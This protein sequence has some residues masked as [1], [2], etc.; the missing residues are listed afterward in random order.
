MTRQ[1]GKIF[2]FDLTLN[3]FCGSNSG[4]FGVVLRWG[5][6]PDLRNAPNAPLFN[7][8]SCTDAATTLSSADGAI[9]LDLAGNPASTLY[10]WG[11]NGAPD[12][13]I[14]LPDDLNDLEAGYYTAMVQD[15]DGCWGVADTSVGGTTLQQPAIMRE[16][17][18]PYDICCSGC[19]INDADADGICDDD[20]N[21][22]DQSAPNFADPANTECIEP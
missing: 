21:C 10:L 17:I 1:M 8:I 6:G 19:G 18:I 14:T 13:T 4:V 22:T 16:I 20:D 5:P 11:I 9:S 2:D 3:V 7:G 12:T 15:S